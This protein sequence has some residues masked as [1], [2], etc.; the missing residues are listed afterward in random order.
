MLLGAIIKSFSVKARY[1]VM[2]AKKDRF[3]VF[4]LKCSSI[5][6]KKKVEG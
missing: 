1:E 3:L 4:T 2:T 5:K 6:K